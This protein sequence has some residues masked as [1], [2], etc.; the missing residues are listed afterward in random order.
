MRLSQVHIHTLREVH[1][2]REQERG[3][4]HQNP[5]GNLQ[6][7]DRASAQ[8]LDQDPRE[9]ARQQAGDFGP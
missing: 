4:Q 3:A 6:C 7:T 9:K 8:E 2:Q 1:G 5:D